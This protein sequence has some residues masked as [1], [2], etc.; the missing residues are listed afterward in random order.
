MAR[1]SNTCQDRVG[2]HL[3]KRSLLMRSTFETAEEVHGG[4]PFKFL[5]MQTYAGILVAIVFLISNNRS[6][7]CQWN[8]SC[9]YSN[10]VA[11][12]VLW[13]CVTLIALLLLAKFGKTHAYLLAWR[14]NALLVLFI[15]Y[16]IASISWSIVPQRSFHT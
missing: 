8:A 2:G 14:R 16:S 10:A 5:S 12:Y 13:G 6:L 11:D 15:L 1:Y 4:Q 3:W 7:M 9:R